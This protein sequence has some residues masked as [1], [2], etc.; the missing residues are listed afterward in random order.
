MCHRWKDI[1][2]GS[3]SLRGRLSVRFRADNTRSGFTPANLPPVTTA[4][5]CK[6][7]K[8]E[9]GGWW[10]QF[11]RNME[12][13]IFH[14]C[15]MSVGEMFYLLRHCPR[16]KRIEMGYVGFRDGPADNNF[17]LES[18]EE[19]S[20]LL[21]Y[22]CSENPVVFD[23]FGPIF[24]RLKSFSLC[25]A[26][27]WK[28]SDILSLSK[29]IQAVQGTLQILQLPPDI[30]L[31][32]SLVKS[33]RLHL[34]QADFSVDCNSPHWDLKL[35]TK[36]CQRQWKMQDFGLRGNNTTN[37]ARI[38]PFQSNSLKYIIPVFPRP[39]A[40]PSNTCPS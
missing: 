36:F 9:V 30:D 13:L 23:Q 40:S 37:E 3:P 34:K 14:S 31:F 28:A 35:W 38:F 11:G 16:L 10:P 32:D 22:S 18:L 24:P 20:V 21:I 27:N 2:L 5:F 15:Q 12:S 1:V 8:L 6:F 29:F 7:E 39:F 19:L 17:K 33:D 4:S 25:L 26:C